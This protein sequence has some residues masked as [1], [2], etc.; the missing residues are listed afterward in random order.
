M[1]PQLFLVLKVSQVLEKKLNP[2]NTNILDKEEFE[3]QEIFLVHHQLLVFFSKIDVNDHYQF[4]VF[5]FF[6][7]ILLTK[8]LQ[9]ILME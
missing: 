5:V 4:H 6:A 9:H 3:N 7:L 8:I 2:K 1:F